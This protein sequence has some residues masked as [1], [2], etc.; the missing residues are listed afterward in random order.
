MVTRQQT[1]AC[2]LRCCKKEKAYAKYNSQRWLCLYPQLA[3]TSQLL[4]LAPEV[5]RL[6]A[7]AWAWAQGRRSVRCVK[8][9]KVNMKN[10]SLEMSI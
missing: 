3:A 4:V 7:I 5:Q 9:R 10:R 6:S 8:S 1:A 2:Q